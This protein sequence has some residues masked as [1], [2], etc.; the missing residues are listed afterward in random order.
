M[1]VFGCHCGVKRT[2]S[3]KIEYAT[4]VC[5]GEMTFL[6]KTEDQPVETSE[7]AEWRRKLEALRARS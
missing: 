6:H 4:C 3:D 1:K 5:G 2:V 7:R